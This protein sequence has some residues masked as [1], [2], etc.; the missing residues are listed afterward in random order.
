LGK[1]A[2][3]PRELLDAAD[4]L[5]LMGN[6]AAHVHAKDYDNIGKEEAEL[7]IDLAKEL[8]KAVYQYASLLT[9]LV[10]LKKPAAGGS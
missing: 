9:K 5:R 6:D 1:T 3:V 2:L 4:H 8:L 7:A 10:S